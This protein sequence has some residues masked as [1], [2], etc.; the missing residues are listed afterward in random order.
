MKITIGPYVGQLINVESTKRKYR[1]RR[2]FSYDL[3]KESL[4]WYDK[5]VF[6][7]LR[8]ADKVSHP[9]NVLTDNRNRKVKIQIDHYDVWN[10]DHT[11]ALIIHPLLQRMQA[12]SICLSFSHWDILKMV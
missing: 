9:I 10:A 8:F 1:S 12:N 7:I 2:G 3:S 11:L 6:T 4:K 5:L